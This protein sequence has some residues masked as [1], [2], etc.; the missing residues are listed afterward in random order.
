MELEMKA[1]LAAK[2]YLELTDH[3]VI[4][5]DFLGWI[6]IEDDEGL[7]FVDV[8]CTTDPMPHEVLGI[9]REAFED[10]MQKYF[11]EERE[12]VDVPIRCDTVELFVCGEG[13]AI[14]RHHVNV[15][16]EV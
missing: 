10:V 8:S 7:A 9:K 12:P 4:K 14:V 15:R 1:K 5:D 11:E 2:H 13:R 3:H 6:V 16:F